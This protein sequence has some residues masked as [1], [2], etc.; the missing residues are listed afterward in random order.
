MQ[1]VYYYNPVDTLIQEALMRE[2]GDKCMIRVLIN[3][4]CS[5]HNINVNMDVPLL[6]Y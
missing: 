4:S 5:G 2:H 1:I 6:L 3:L